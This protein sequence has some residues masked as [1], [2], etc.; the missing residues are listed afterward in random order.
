MLA[1]ALTAAALAGCG[2]GSSGD[3]EAFCRAATDTE[4]FSTIF[5]QLDPTNV[6]A[7]LPAF[8][9]ARTQEEELRADAPAAVRSDIDLLIGFFDDLIAGLQDADRTQVERPAIY[10]ELRPR[11]D[12]VQAASN[13]IKLYVDSNC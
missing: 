5:D 3:P 6:D 2:G 7:A 13:R 8:Q 10:D 9:T 4:R 12:Q 11:F 1:I